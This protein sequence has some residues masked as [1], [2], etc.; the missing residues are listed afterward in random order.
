[1][2]L[3]NLKERLLRS[4]VETLR[5]WANTIEWKVSQAQPKQEPSITEEVNSDEVSHSADYSGFPG[6]TIEY[7]FTPRVHGAPQHW[8]DL[9]RERAP[10]LLDLPESRPMPQRPVDGVRPDNLNEPTREESRE[11]SEGEQITPRKS[12]TDQFRR[13]H[14]LFPRMHRGSAKTKAKTLRR[15]NSFTIQPPKK[16]TSPDGPVEEFSNRRVDLNEQSSLPTQTSSQSPPTQEGSTPVLPPWRLTPPTISGAAD[17][18]TDVRTPVDKSQRKV[19]SDMLEATNVK[20]LSNEEPEPQRFYSAAEPPQERYRVS[21]SSDFNLETM[22]R[23]KSRKSEKSSSFVEPNP[24]T[25]LDSREEH[26]RKNEINFVFTPPKVRDT[27]R[28]IERSFALSKQEE[29][30]AY[31]IPKAARRTSPLPS[32]TLSR[33][34]VTRS[35]ELEPFQRSDLNMPA[36]INEETMSS[37][38]TVHFTGLASGENPWPDLPSPSEPDIAEEIA[39][40]ERELD[41]YRRLEREQKGTLWNE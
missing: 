27:A 9:V 15:P 8:I 2:I 14:Q 34:G 35:Q 31:S 21:G 4:I 19:T 26:R 12:D 5:G 17:Q 1:M 24:S 39:A 40:H 6:K 11:F 29:S 38:A 10:E 7:R 20:K 22:P 37:A 3:G 16:T 33:I 18:P 32:F 23:S 30:R 41:R 13:D 28:F 25:R 36:L